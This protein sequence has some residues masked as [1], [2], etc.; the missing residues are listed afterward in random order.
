[1]SPL[2]PNSSTHRDTGT[3]LF[4]TL[5]FNWWTL[6]HSLAGL[7]WSVRAFWATSAPF[8]IFFCKILSRKYQSLCWKIIVP[9]CPY[10]FFRSAFSGVELL[11]RVALWVTFHLSTETYMCSLINFNSRTMSM[12]LK[13][14]NHY[15]KIRFTKR[16][17]NDSPSI[18]I[19]LHGCLKTHS[20]H[21]GSSSTFSYIFESHKSKRCFINLPWT[22]ELVQSDH[23][24]Q[25][26]ST[27]SEQGRTPR[28]L[29]PKK[30]A[31]QKYI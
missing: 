1:M 14:K 2:R 16:F 22:Q 17:K 9:T 13:T 31:I 18:T 30:F 5:T 24:E 7:F 4:F 19:P 20:D 10:K 28:L 3:V 12:P 21:C 6:I 23:S 11:K 25:Q 29:A 27:V 8:W 15:L 26:G